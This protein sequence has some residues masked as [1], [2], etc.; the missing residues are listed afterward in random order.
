MKEFLGIGGYTRVPEG[1]FSWQHL[2][3]VTA[4]I[5]IMTVLAVWLGRRYKN[6]SDEEK[7]KVLV[8][9]AILINAFEIFKI[10]VLAIRGNDPA[11]AIMHNLPLFLCSIQLINIPV[12]AFAKGRLKE[13]A[14]DFVFIFGLVGAVLGTYGAGQNYACYPVLSMDNVV[15]GITHTISG[16]AALYVVIVGLVTMKKQNMWITYSILGA[17]CAMAFATNYLARFGGYDLNYMFLIRG[18]GTPYD[19]FLNLVGGNPVI[20][21]I[22]VVGMFIACITLFYVC[23]H[24]IKS[25]AAKKI[26][27]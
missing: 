16:F 10:V 26:E 13:A 17:F 12:A 22:L 9:A 15:S 18:D 11:G 6:R 5:I 24:L 20:Y 2:T 3:F 27:E 1:Y 8:A 25:K 14:I 21:P 7:N 4:L 19:F 23:Y